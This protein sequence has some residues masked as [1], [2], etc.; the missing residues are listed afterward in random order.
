MT[1]TKKTIFTIFLFFLILNITLISA[2]ID[3]ANTPTGTVTGSSAPTT[4]TP[5]ETQVLSILPDGSGSGGG[6]TTAVGGPCRPPHNTDG[7]CINTDTTQCSGT[8]I[9]TRACNGTW[10]CSGLN[11]IRCCVGTSTSTGTGTSGTVAGTNNASLSFRNSDATSELDLINNSYY[12]GTLPSSGTVV[13]VPKFTIPL[14]VKTSNSGKQIWIWLAKDPDND[15]SYYTSEEDA[16]SKL[17]CFYPAAAEVSIT[18][19]EFYWVD[20]EDTNLQQGDY[21][22]NGSGVK[23][24]IEGNTLHF[25]ENEACQSGLFFS[26]YMYTADSDSGLSDATNA[27]YLFTK[28]NMKIYIVTAESGGEVTENNPEGLR[29]VGEEKDSGFGVIAGHHKELTIR[30]NQDDTTYYFKYCA[31]VSNGTSTS[32]M[33]SNSDSPAWAAAI[34]AVGARPSVE[35]TTTPETPTTPVAET[36]ECSTCSTIAQCLGCIDKDKFVPGVFKPKN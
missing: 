6:S 20:G 3:W 11:N 8:L 7:T 19:H 15:E 25:K 18:G 17:K 26:K 1:H 22:L 33:V 21:W 36:A 5:A 28:E 24:K 16:Q 23:T 31:A 14:D 12:A 35:E 2:D 32:P 10:C 9:T 34:L 13:V 30:P 29:A 4:T 27:V